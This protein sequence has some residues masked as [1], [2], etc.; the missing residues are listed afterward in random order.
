[1]QLQ[2]NPT[3]EHICAILLESQGKLAELF[4]TSVERFNHHSTTRWFRYGVICSKLLFDFHCVGKNKTLLK[5]SEVDEMTIYKQAD[6][7]HYI[8][9]FYANMYTSKP[10]SPDIAKAQRKC[11]ENVPSRVMEHMN[12]EMT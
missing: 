8:S 9:Q 4:Q 7:S 5:E 2:S 1:M 6:L 12:V 3:K 11:W 10:H